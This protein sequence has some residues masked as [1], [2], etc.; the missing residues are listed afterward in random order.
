MRSSEEAL[1]PI[2]FGSAAIPGENDRHFATDEESAF[3]H[4]EENQVFIGG[5]RGSEKI[6]IPDKDFSEV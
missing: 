3:S 6:N 2:H 4:V 1:L 5:K